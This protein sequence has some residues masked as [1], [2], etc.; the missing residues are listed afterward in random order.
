[1]D[2]KA[3]NYICVG[4]TFEKDGTTYV[5]RE[6]SANNC[7]GCAFYNINAEGVPECKGLD[8]QC[9]EN[10]RKDAKNVVFQTINKGE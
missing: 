9:N 2:N 1:M 8:F 5:V 6:A 7:A 3:K 4:T 10:Y